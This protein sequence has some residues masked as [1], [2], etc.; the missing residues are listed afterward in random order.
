MGQQGFSQGLPPS[1]TP[2]K[3][4]ATAE[5]FTM[6][7]PVEYDS[8]QEVFEHLNQV[9]QEGLLPDHAEIKPPEH[10]RV[11][12]IERNKLTKQLR[13]FADGFNAAEAVSRI[14]NRCE[15]WYATMAVSLGRVSMMDRRDETAVARLDHSQI[16]ANEFELIADVLT[17]LNVKG[18]HRQRFRP[19]ITLVKVPGATGDEKQFLSRELQDVIPDEVSLRPL[20]TYP[21]K[22]PQARRAS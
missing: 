20:Q 14:N 17:S 1:Q 10:M 3:K 16:I 11:T 2:K 5:A 22:L 7:R 6:F 19:H 4:A 21:N 13:G 18:M 15:S 12:Y 8:A 9:K